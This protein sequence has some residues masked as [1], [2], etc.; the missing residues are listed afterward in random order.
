MSALERLLGSSGRN[1]QIIQKDKIQIN[2][3][4][5]KFH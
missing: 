5:R 2:Q 1:L 3:I 4:Q